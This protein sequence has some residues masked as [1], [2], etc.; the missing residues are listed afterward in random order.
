VALAIIHRKGD[1]PVAWLSATPVWKTCLREV[2]FI[3][4]AGSVAA[5]DELVRDEAAYGL[6]LEILCGLRSPMVGETQVMGQFREFLAGLDTEHGWLQQLGQRVL[7]DARRI[8]ERHLRGLGSRS[9]GSAVRRHLLDCGRV[10]LIGAGALAQEILPFAA[11][12][13]RTVDQWGRRVPVADGRAGIIFHLI[14]AAA[15]CPRVEAPAALV[16]AA[17]VPSRDVSRVA[18]RYVALRRLIDLRDDRVAGRLDLQAPVVTLQD[19]FDE[20][21]DAREAAGAQIAA[22]KGE[23]ADLSRAFDRR[24]QL[25]PFGWDD[26]CA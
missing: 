16:V 17:P 15:R 7:A 13:G 18:S 10:A 19:L 25:R 26:L 9:Y 12:D 1:Q 6:L 2:A 23:I 3:N 22:A 4:G 8:R 5:G 20:M 24:D 14:D 21:Q 11:D